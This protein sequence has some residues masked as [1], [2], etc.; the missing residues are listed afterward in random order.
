MGNPWSDE[1]TETHGQV[2]ERH[3]DGGGDLVKTDIWEKDSAGRTTTDG[4][5]SVIDGERYDHYGNH[6]GSAGDD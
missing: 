5:S 4:H 2:I 3:Y 6:I 1:T